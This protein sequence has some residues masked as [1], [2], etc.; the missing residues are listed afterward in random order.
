MKLT[1]ETGICAGCEQLKRALWEA[2]NR[3]A[4]SVGGDP[5]CRTRPSE[6]SYDSLSRTQAVADIDATVMEIRNHEATQL[7]THTQLGCRGHAEDHEI[8]RLQAVMIDVRGFLR[9]LARRPVLA[10]SQELLDA[11]GALEDLIGTETGRLRSVLLAV[12]G[13]LRGLAFH[14]ELGC[15]AQD[16]L[17]GAVALDRV[18]SVKKAAP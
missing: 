15:C 4:V 9:G 14:P 13:Y 5:T 2:I 3:H 12:R 17:D 11:V 6:R 18:L 8:G 7:C 1:C 16:L 10:R